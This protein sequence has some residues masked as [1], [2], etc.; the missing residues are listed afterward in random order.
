MFFF[1]LQRKGNNLF[2]TLNDRSKRMAFRKRKMIL[3]TKIKMIGKMSNGVSERTGNDWRV[4]T[5]LL[6]WT[7]AEVVNRIWGTL[8]NERVDEF[9]KSRLKMGDECLVEVSFSTRCFRTGYC[10]NDINI[11]NIKKKD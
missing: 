7:E 6:E 1:E 3:V 2:N 11:I 10:K 5:V 8:F 4:L 9:E